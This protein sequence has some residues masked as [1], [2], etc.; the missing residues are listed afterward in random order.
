MAGL[1]EMD[2]HQDLSITPTNTLRFSITRTLK[3]LSSLV[4]G[5]SNRSGMDDLAS[6]LS[7][8]ADRQFPRSLGSPEP[9]TCEEIFHV[10]SLYEACARKKN[11]RISRLLSTLESILIGGD[12]PKVVARILLLNVWIASLPRFSRR[13]ASMVK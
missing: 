7:V 10:K 11:T 4:E 5:I 2:K 1:Y 3:S 12:G 13:S 6:E 9:L 8:T